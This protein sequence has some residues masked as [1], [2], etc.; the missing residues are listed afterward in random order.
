[1]LLFWS[2]LNIVQKLLGTINIHVLELVFS[3]LQ[4]G[5]EFL[6]HWIYNHHI[7]ICISKRNILCGWIMIHLFAVMLGLDKITE[8][9]NMANDASY[10]VL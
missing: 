6:A 5:E 8:W 10:S 2:S 4:E 7:V 9:V 3:Q 1:M